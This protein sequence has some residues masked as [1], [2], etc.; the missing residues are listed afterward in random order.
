[1]ISIALCVLYHDF[2]I[3]YKTW[4]LEI[5]MSINDA[6]LYA[7]EKTAKWSKTLNNSERIWIFIYSQNA[8]RRMKKFTH[9]LANEIHKTV[10][11]LI[12]TQ[13]NIHWI[14]EHADI[15]KNEKANQLAKSMFLSSIITRD[16]FISFKFLNDQITK[17]NLQ[18]WLKSWKNNTKN[19]SS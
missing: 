1:M 2:R 10:E 4:N 11:N 12:N 9:F 13:F 19:V 16:E 5:E 6:K 3:A 18:K 17:Y 15:S 7:I 14:S 8:I